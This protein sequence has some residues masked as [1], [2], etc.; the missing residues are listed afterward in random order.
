M[1]AHLTVPLSA[2]CSLQLIILYMLRNMLSPS[3]FWLA[4]TSMEAVTLG[5]YVFVG[6]K[7]RPAKENPLLSIEMADFE[8]PEDSDDE[9]AAT[10]TG[11]PRAPIGNKSA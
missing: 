10:L 9:E 1:T 2:P 11:A 4:D 8:P 5:L 6:V 7:F 3:S